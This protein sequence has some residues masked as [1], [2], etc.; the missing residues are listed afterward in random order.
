MDKSRLKEL[1]ASAHKLQPTVRIGKS[2]ITTAVIEELKAQVKNKKIVKVK[3]L[4]EDRHEVKR[5]SNELSE[6]TGAEIIDVRGNVI[7]LWKEGK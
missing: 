2:G 6:H 5:I 7:V 4:G 3:V 1:K